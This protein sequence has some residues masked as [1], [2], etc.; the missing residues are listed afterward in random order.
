MEDIDIIGQFG[1]GF[2]SAFMVSDKVTV[3]S[4]AYGAEEAYQWESSG[5]DGY[6]ITDAVKEGHGTEITL[7][8]K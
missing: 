4:K 1:V 8:I 5:A 2:Y 3:V 7:H 6:T